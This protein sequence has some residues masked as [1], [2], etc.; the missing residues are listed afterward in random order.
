MS[1]TL[2]FLG[3]AATVTGSKTLLQTNSQKHLIDCGL[4]QGHREL[5]N[6]NWLP[7]S[8]PAKTLDSVLLTHAHLDHAGYLPK[9]A[10]EGFG[11]PIHTSQGSADLCEILLLDS[12]H[13]Q[14]EDAAYANR[15]K[16]SKHNPAL[17]LYDTEDAKKA[18]KLLRP[19]AREEWFRVGEGIEA[20]F[21]RSGHIIGS[22]IIQVSVMDGGNPRLITFSGDLGHARS[23]TLKGPV[24][25]LETDVLIIEST[26]GDRAHPRTDPLDALAEIALRTF[27]RKGVLIIP[28][29]SVGRSQEVLHLFRVLEDSG[30]IPRVPVIL[31]SPMSNAATRIFLKHPEDSPLESSFIG[32]GDNFFPRGFEPVVSA[33]DSMMA[34]M[35]DG[36]MVVIAAAGMLNGGRILHH[37]K[38]RLPQ[39]KNTVLF[40]GY[41]AEGTKGR[42]LQDQ[43]QSMGSMRIHHQ[44]VPVEAEVSSIQNLSA[45]G[46][47]QDLV[48][49][50][51]HFEKKPSKIFVNHG[52][53]ASA[54]ALASRITR[55]LGLRA[56][57]VKMDQRITLF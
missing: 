4:F 9:L 45:H 44:E 32:S 56:E 16:H 17:P 8:P 7:F 46:D 57:A 40:V 39:K 20:K 31:D 49:W 47:A 2:D 42:F 5:R 34:C 41:Q 33:D 48:E 27:Q 12:A 53:P 26:Y 6:R 23:R 28:A 25:V 38:H 24:E 30:R 11:G 10:K 37:L 15:T 1:I 54:E 18:L 36:P 51:G 55:E 43:G 14:E 19:H 22:S 52:T 35:R 3:A 13:L 29:F 21:L 50:I